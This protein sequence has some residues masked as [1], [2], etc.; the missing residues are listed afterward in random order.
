[1][2]GRIRNQRSYLRIQLAQLIV[3]SCP[4]P[5]YPITSHRFAG[6]LGGS[7][8]RFGSRCASR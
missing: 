7:R 1:M 6:F 2:D 4:V 5:I 3:P 8:E